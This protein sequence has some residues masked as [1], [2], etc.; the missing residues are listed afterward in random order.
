MPTQSKTWQRKI[1]AAAKADGY[2]D[3]FWYIETT[4]PGLRVFPAAYPGRWIPLVPVGPDPEASR[5]IAGMV[6]HFFRLSNPPSF[7]F[8]EQLTDATALEQTG[9]LW[10]RWDCD[11]DVDAVCA[12]CGC[13]ERVGHT[14]IEGASW[15][16]VE[17][18]I[19]KGASRANQTSL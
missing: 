15:L 7:T 5:R 12:D 4:A 16:C 9:C 14:A 8:A 1:L 3:L 6:A 19:E 13:V 17:C 2:A 10:Y 11:V 18:A